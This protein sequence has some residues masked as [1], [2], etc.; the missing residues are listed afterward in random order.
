[1]RVSWAPSCAEIKSALE[2]LALYDPDWRINTHDAQPE[3]RR[4][5]MRLKSWVQINNKVTNSHK[6]HMEVVR[7]MATSIE[8]IASVRHD[9]GHGR[10]SYGNSDFGPLVLCRI[11]RPMSYTSPIHPESW[12][13]GTNVIARYAKVPVEIIFTERFL[14]SVTSSASIIIREIEDYRAEAKRLHKA[15]SPKNGSKSDNQ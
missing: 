11:E 7:D 3:D 9:L 2:Y 5:A 13:K 6:G 4:L 15:A 1:M 14:Q 12:E 10:L 8:R